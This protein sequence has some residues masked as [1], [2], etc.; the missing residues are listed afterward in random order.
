MFA[1]NEYFEGKVKSIAFKM[2]LG[3][4]CRQA[5]RRPQPRAG[6]AGESMAWSLSL[7]APAPLAQQEHLA[8]RPPLLRSGHSGDPVEIH[9]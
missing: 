8:R 4:R 2:W 9:A 6:S 3:R 7:A 5:G 1:T